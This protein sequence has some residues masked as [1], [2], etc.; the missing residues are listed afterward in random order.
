MFTIDKATHSTTLAHHWH[1]RPGWEYFIS[2]PHTYRYREVSWNGGSLKSSVLDWDF[3]KHPVIGVPIY[4]FP[5]WKK[6]L[7]SSCIPAAQ[8]AMRGLGTSAKITTRMT[9]PQMARFLISSSS[10]IPTCPGRSRMV[11]PPSK[12]LR[13]CGVQSQMFATSLRKCL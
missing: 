2:K 7:P 10:M 1:S 8:M 12:D 9:A 6:H 5:G 13:E 11:G 4:G 3:T